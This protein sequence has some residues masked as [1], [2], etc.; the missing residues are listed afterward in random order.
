MGLMNRNADTAP[1]LPGP[2][3]RARLA[4]LTVVIAAA[5]VGGAGGALLYEAASDPATVATT[6]SS[7]NVPVADTSSELTIGDI[8]A[9]ASPGVVQVNVTAEVQAGPFGETQQQEGEGT[10]FVYD[11]EGHIVTN[12]HVVEGATSVSVTLSDGSTHD[13]KVVGTDASSDLAV[14]QVDVPAADLHPL[15]LGNSDDL[16]VGD[17]VIA[18]G[19][20]YGLENTVTSGIVSALGRE[21]DSPNGSTITGA[22]QTDA[23][24]NKGNSGGPLLNDEGEVIGVN[25][26]ITSQSGGSEGVGFAIASNTVSAVVAQLL[27]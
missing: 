2:R 16:E 3:I 8:A 15:T 27:A 9:S 26:Q 4:A 22:I 19:S 21:I 24:I 10:G 12:E 5:A 7:S 13:A 23:A 6:V 14:L 18:I 20:P 17:G 11:T 1:P 25:A